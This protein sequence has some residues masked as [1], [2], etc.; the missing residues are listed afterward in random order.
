MWVYFWGLYPVH[1]I[2]VSVFMPT[3]YCFDYYGIIV[4]FDIGLSNSSNFALLSQDCCCYVGPFVIPYKFLKYSNSVKYEI[5][6]LIGISFNLQIALVS[7]NILMMLILSI[8]E[9]DMCFP[10]FVLLQFISL[11]LIIFQVQVFYTLG[12]VYSQILYSF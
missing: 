1:L 8:H 7:M 6:I 2:Y 3:P 4:Q 10:L 11:C 12:Q 5:R 9:Q